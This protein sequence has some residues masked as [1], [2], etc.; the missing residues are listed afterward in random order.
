MTS[1]SKKK[2]KNHDYATYQDV[3]ECCYA[4]S[5]GWSCDTGLI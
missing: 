3:G 1:Q 4:Y 2:K 5:V